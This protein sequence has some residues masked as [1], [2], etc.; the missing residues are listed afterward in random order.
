MEEENCVILLNTENYINYE[1]KSKLH[2]IHIYT[3]VSKKQ[4]GVN[5]KLDME[6]N[7][8][9]N[10]NFENIGDRTLNVYLSNKYNNIRYS[11]KSAIQGES[12]SAQQVG[13]YYLRNKN[14][15]MALTYF[16]IAAD[17]MNNIAAY[18]VGNIYENGADG[19]D[20]DIESAVKYYELSAKL[21]HIPALEK[22]AHIYENGIDNIDQDI[23]KSIKYYEEI[24]AIEK[25]TD[26]FYILGNIY[27]NVQKDI[28]KAIE[29]YEQ[30]ANKSHIKSIY[31][32]GNIYENVQKDIPKAIE[33]YKSCV[34]LG[35]ADAIQKLIDI[36][37][38][39]KDIQKAIEY[40]KFSA[41]RGNI[42][43]I[44]KLIGIYENGTDEIKINTDEAQ[45]YQQELFFRLGERYQFGD[46]EDIDINKAIEFYKKADK[47][48]RALRSLAYMYEIGND[49][50]DIDIDLSKEYYK[51]ANILD[52]D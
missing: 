30:A 12:E 29:Y 11:Y 39:E 16:I 22:I 49:E 8:M 25:R 46:E 52:P 13:Y 48:A 3:I 2:K 26:I 28:S 41:N 21:R 24:L 17:Q 20:K 50:I 14:I 43:A 42:D 5:S 40:Y 35:S 31:K 51:R 32:L 4:P 34:N 36:Y 6:I 44:Q 33:Y 23:N 9:L 18:E 38:K 45:K 1:N 7:Y 47:N 19:V 15:D 37:E 10:H 27:E